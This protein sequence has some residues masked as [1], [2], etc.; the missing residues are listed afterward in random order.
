MFSSF[1]RLKKDSKI[2]DFCQQEEKLRREYMRL[3]QQKIK[4]IHLEDEL[5]PRKVLKRLKRNAPPVLFCKG[6][7]NLL[8]G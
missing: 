5:Y 8:K 6:N 7:L 4:I 2:T 1:K 3:K